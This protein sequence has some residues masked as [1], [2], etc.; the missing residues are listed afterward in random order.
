[1][2]VLQVSAELFPWV[3]TGGLAD[4]AA[5]LP[6]ALAQQ[7][8]DVRLLLPGFPAFVAALTQ[9]EDVGTVPYPWGGG[10]GRLVQGRL[11]ALTVYLLRDAAFD[12]PGNPYQDASG[13]A[14]ADNARRFALLGAAAAQLAAGGGGWQPQTVHGHDWHAG[15]IDEMVNQHAGQP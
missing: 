14:Y 13:Q 12:R 8:V 9:P 10:A 6:V 2:R 1:V 11:G 3:K 5:A 7:G 15:W 4:V